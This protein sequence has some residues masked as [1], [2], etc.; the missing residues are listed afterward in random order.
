MTTIRKI[1]VY[2]CPSCGE[3]HEY[4][5]DAEACCA[6]ATEVPRWRCEECD[7]VHETAEAAC[8]CCQEEPPEEEEEPEVVGPTWEELRRLAGVFWD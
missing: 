1:T 6:R 5:R 2:G 4:R 3:E 8:A 7:T